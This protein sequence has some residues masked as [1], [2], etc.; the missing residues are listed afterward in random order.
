VRLFHSGDN[1]DMV[2]LDAV[3]ILKRKAED[4]SLSGDGVACLT[5]A[6]RYLSVPDISDIARRLRAAVTTPVT[7]LEGRGATPAV[8]TETS[9]STPETRPY[10]FKNSEK[11]A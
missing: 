1:E 3:A 10:I 9:F 8:S 11:R 4:T 6:A 5:R 7:F 2:Y